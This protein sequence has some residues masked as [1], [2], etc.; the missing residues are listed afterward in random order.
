[1]ASAPLSSITSRTFGLP[2]SLHAFGASLVLLPLGIASSVLIA[3]AVGPAGK[4]SFDL[5]VATAALLAMILSLSLPAGVTYA[6]AQGRNNPGPLALQ[7]LIISTLQGLTALVFLSAL[8]LTGYSGRFL[9]D[10]MGFWIVVGLALYVW[11]E[12]LTK[13]WAAMLT[14]Q[15]QIA[16]VNNSEVIGRVAQFVILFTLAGALYVSD[17]RLSVGALF[18]V[19][20]TATVFINLLLFKALNPRFHTLRDTGALKEASAFAFPSYLANSVQFLN[21][22]LDVF[23]VGLF[24][25]TAS[26]GRYTLAVS[27]AQLLWLLSNSAA[28]VLLPKIAASNDRAASV[29]H[30][31]RVARLSLAASLGGALAL[32]VFAW[33]AIPLLYGEAFRPSI[34]AL[35]WILPGIVAFSI[36]NVLAAF[37]AGIGQPRLNLYV[38]CVS[39]VVTVVLD[40]ILIPKFNIVGASIAS[41]ASYLTSAVLT[42][43]LFA[44][45]TGIG[46]KEVLIPTADD[47]AFVR[48]LAQPLFKAT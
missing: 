7:L 27:L 9:P 32:G 33:L 30:V 11:V 14:G 45:N 28:A 20:F 6:V 31:S 35:W 37:L 29:Q 16:V 40:F 43:F 1:M 15:Q 36:V 46:V 25:G 39:L 10:T 2:R 41:S 38:G 24:A 21:Y 12:L 23:I 47:I 5:I 22:R 44:R 3:R 26:V 18:L 48:Q 19:S 13:Y 42:T 34:L 17:R 4:G 8:R